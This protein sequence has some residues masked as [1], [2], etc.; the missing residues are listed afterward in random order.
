MYTHPE[1]MYTSTQSSGKLLPLEHLVRI[2]TQRPR[3]P[4]MHGCSQAPVDRHM[5]HQKGSSEND[6]ASEFM[7]PY[8]HRCLEI[9]AV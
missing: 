3:I 4:C 6:N 7:N 5:T 1:L 8:T 2:G 9:G